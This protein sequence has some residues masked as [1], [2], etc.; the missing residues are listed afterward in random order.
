MAEPHLKTAGVPQFVHHQDD[1]SASAITPTDDVA[2]AFKQHMQ[3]NYDSQ[4]STSGLLYQAGL[5]PVY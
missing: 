3:S 2:A 1:I 4:D 5:K